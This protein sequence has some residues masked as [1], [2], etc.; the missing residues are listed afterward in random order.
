MK[1]RSL[2]SLKKQAWKLCSE[3]IRRRSAVCGLCACVCCGQVKPWKQLHASHLV[4]GRRLGILF[5][6]RGIFPC[7]YGCNVMKSGN[8]R[9]Y[10]AYIDKVFG[11]EYRLNIVEELRRNSKKA[12]KFTSTDYENIIEDYKEKLRSLND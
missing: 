11:R 3:F 2:K 10:D 12:V 8:Y 9:E 5:D 4:P 7:C 6:E 1:K